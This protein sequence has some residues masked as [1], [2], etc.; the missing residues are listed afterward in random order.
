[1]TLN[2]FCGI[3][4]MLNYTASIFEQAGSSLSPSM[5]AIIVAFIQVLGSYTATLLVERAGR[6][7]LYMVSTIG[8]GIGLSV[9]SV[10]INL[11]SRGYDCSDFSWVPIGSFSL[12]IF[13][14]QLAIL[15]LPFLVIAELLPPKIRSFGSNICLTLLWFL[16]FS[17][18]K[19]ILVIVYFQKLINFQF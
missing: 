3:F 8:A 16:S 17:V 6:K 2:Q 5:S 11:S 1:M 9:L 19:V 10:Y 7:I 13:C 12:T 18:L 4:S 14:A 15:S